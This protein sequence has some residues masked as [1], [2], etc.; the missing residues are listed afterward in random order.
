MAYKKRSYTK[1]RTTYRKK[2][3]VV[4]RAVQ[5]AK[6]RV[7]AKK[8]KAVVNRAAETKRAGSYVNNFACTGF[9][10]NG[11]AS[12]IKV[13]GPSATVG[14]ALYNIQQGAG[15]GS[16]VGNKITT[17][18]LVMKGCVHI[19]TSYD[20]TSNY[21][22][23]PLYVACYIFRLKPSLDDTQANA[24]TIMSQSFFQAGNSSAGFSGLLNDL[25]RDVNKDQVQLLKKR[26]FRVGVANVLSAFGVNNPSNAN[27]QYADGTVG[28]S[29]MFKMD[30][31]KCLQKTLVFNDTTNTP[32]NRNTYIAWVPVRVDGSAI[33][34]GIG[35]LSGT[36]PCYVD[37]GLDYYYKDM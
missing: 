30:L 24:Y 26:V 35:S 28:I 23:C 12:T 19:N 9:M 6:K 5:K 22:M 1:K 27:Q 8:V 34:T 13:I 31:T 17:T 10:S 32:S 36:I 29:K 15:Q 2:G 21:N 18:K 25:T 37:W 7:F 3:G 4:R 33:L 20:A 11:F 14:P 16:R